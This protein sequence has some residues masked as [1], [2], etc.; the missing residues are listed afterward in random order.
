[1]KKVYSIALLSLGFCFGA[2]GTNLSANAS[3]LLQDNSR[4]I[5]AGDMSNSEM[6]MTNYLLGT[7]ANKSREVMLISVEDGRSF[8]TDGYIKAGTRVLVGIDSNGKYHLVSSD[9]SDWMSVLNKDTTAQRSKML[10]GEMGTSTASMNRMDVD[11]DKIDTT[12]YDPAGSDTE[13]SSMNRTSNMST[14]TSSVSDPNDLDSTRVEKYGDNDNSTTQMN[15]SRTDT[16]SISDRDDLDS[17]RVEKYSDESDNSTTQ[18]NTSRTDTRSISDRDDLDS[19]RVEKYSDNDSTTQMNTTSQ[20]NNSNSMD[21]DDDDDDMM[22][23]NQSQPVRGL[24]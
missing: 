14:S 5:L 18:M 22:M 2:V 6:K 4:T 17:T 13:T 15:T 3:E 11:N 10:M 8:E 19:T 23:Q 24:W 20:M 9:K 1:M 16:R 21:M 7:V 12:V